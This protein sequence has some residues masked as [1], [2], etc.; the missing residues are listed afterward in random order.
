MDGDKENKTDSRQAKPKAGLK[1]QT[2]DK[3]GQGHRYQD[4]IGEEV[5]WPEEKKRLIFGWNMRVTR[6][7]RAQRAAGTSV[8]GLIRK[9]QRNAYVVRTT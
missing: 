1:R 7:T 6:E 4:M 2:I 5:L 9:T 3:S 8:D